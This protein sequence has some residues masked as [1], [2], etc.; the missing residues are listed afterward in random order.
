MYQFVVF[1]GQLGEPL[2]VLQRCNDGHQVPAGM[3]NGNVHTGMSLLQ[4]NVLGQLSMSPV[5][6]VGEVL[7]VELPAVLT[8]VDGVHVLME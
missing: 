6:K 1:G 7:Q 2:V 4:K 3:K 8:Q 5:L